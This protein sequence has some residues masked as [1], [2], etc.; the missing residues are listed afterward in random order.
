MIKQAPVL[1]VGLDFFEHCFLR[2]TVECT[3]SISTSEC[4]KSYQ[5]VCYFI[6]ANITA[7]NFRLL[8]YHINFFF[9]IVRTYAAIT[10]TSVSSASVTIVSISCL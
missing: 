2:L 1:R 3:D 6:W 5:R 8:L 4:M 9:K 7:F 10:I